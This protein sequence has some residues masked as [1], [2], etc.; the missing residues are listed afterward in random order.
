[1]SQ[2]ALE[3][4][5]MFAFLKEEKFVYLVGEDEQRKVENLQVRFCSKVPKL[6]SPQQKTVFD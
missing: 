1:M 4:Q 5:E 6:V 3:K 2:S